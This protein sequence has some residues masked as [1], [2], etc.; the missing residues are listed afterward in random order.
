VALCVTVLEYVEVFLEMA[1]WG[2]SGH[3]ARWLVVASIQL[4]KLDDYCHI[5]RSR[6]HCYEY[7]SGYL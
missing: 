4:T 1:A 5:H 2:S 6:S 3:T 7:E